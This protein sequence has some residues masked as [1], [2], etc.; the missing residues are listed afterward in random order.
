MLCPQCGVVVAPGPLRER[1]IDTGDNGG[2]AAEARAHRKHPEIGS[3]GLVHRLLS[4]L[5]RR[6]SK[7]HA[8]PAL[9]ASSARPQDR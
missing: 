8:V 5:L 9:V 7:R 4:G 3:R 1:A 6:P 2:I